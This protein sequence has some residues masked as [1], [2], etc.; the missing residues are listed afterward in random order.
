MRREW[1]AGFR[2]RV[3][4]KLVTFS[5]RHAFR[6]GR[7]RARGG[8]RLEPCLA[9]VIRALNDLSKPAA[10][11]RRVNTVRIHARTFDVIDLPSGEVRTT[12]VPF[13][14]LAIRS[15]NKCALTRAYEYSYIAHIFVFLFSDL[16]ARSKIHLQYVERQP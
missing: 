5:H 13:F 3:V 10:G 2:R 12:H 11:L 15:Q 6:R 9:A 14:T 16:S 8:S 4:N 7:R 1:F